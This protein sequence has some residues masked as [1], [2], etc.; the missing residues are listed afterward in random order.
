MN[1][2]GIDRW[3]DKH[4]GSL[5]LVRTLIGFLNLLIGLVI[6]AKLFGWFM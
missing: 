3:S 4:I 5:G 6:V 2:E 1:G